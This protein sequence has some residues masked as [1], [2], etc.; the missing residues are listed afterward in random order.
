M[1]VIAHKTIF[2]LLVH[3]HVSV[4]PSIRLGTYIITLPRSHDFK[5]KL[6]CQT[7]SIFSDKVVRNMYA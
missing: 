4:V 5:Y 2:I 1:Y 6:H 3:F 7:F